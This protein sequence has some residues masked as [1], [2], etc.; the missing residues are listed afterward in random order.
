VRARAIPDEEGRLIV[1]L[2][3]TREVIVRMINNLTLSIFQLSTS[4]LLFS[5]IIFFMTGGERVTNLSR[6]VS[7]RAL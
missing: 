6:L 7:V 2:E 1:P 3:T 4:Q 5:N